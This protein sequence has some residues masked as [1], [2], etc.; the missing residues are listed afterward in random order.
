M[1]FSRLLGSFAAVE[2]IMLNLYHK[3]VSES[4]IYGVD[5]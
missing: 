5:Q 2:K 3:P 4:E 1:N